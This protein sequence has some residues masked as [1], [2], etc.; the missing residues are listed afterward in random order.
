MLNH[1]KHWFEERWPDASWR[2][3]NQLYGSW[4]DLRIEGAHIRIT[5]KRD[6]N[7]LVVWSNLRFFEGPMPH[8]LHLA[9]PDFFAQLKTVI[10]R[11]IKDNKFL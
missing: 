5:E 8:H 3:E 10:Q 4:V 7:L 9:D 1:L 2:E 6:K 11:A